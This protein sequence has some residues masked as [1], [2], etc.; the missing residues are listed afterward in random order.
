MRRHGCSAATASMVA[1][2]EP[3]H[4]SSVGAVSAYLAAVFT[5]KH[6][7][8]RPCCV[9]PYV[10]TGIGTYHTRHALIGSTLFGFRSSSAVWIGIDN[11]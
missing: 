6:T 3:A 11:G 1:G 9:R 8:D 10:V 2:R 7:V 4:T 5:I